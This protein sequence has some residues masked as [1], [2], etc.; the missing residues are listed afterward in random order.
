[1]TVGCASK[2]PVP[3]V[4]IVCFAN[5][6]FSLGVYKILVSLKDTEIQISLKSRMPNLCCVQKRRYR[7]FPRLHTKQK[8]RY[9]RK[10][11]GF[12]FSFFARK[13]TIPTISYVLKPKSSQ[14][15]R[16]CNRG[17]EFGH[18]RSIILPEIT[19]FLENWRH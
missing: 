3:L 10:I 8:R 16:L 5:V 6:L 18:A 12:F 1:M 2:R 11:I 19:K 17:R 7:I 14:L 4:F 13:T 15:G 9:R